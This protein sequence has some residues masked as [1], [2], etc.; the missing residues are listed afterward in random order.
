[1]AMP[2]CVPNSISQ[3]RAH[4]SKSRARISLR[5]SRCF[6]RRRR[7]RRSRA[8]LTTRSSSR[9]SRYRLGRLRGSFGLG[10]LSHPRTKWVRRRAA[11]IGSCRSIW[12]QRQSRFRF[13][14]T[15]ARW[16][17]SFDNRNSRDRF[18][19]LSSRCPAKPVRGLRLLAHV[20]PAGRSV[21][22]SRAPFALD[23]EA[24]SRNARPVILAPN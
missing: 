14:S 24:T 2:P 8:G 21:S 5:R 11:A 3:V 18:S 9:R 12:R 23:V 16:V 17:A 15:A 10:G 6:S 4:R 7:H 1:M 13:R 20:V 19:S 22:P